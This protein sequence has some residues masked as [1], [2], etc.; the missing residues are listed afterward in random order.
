M[1]FIKKMYIMALHIYIKKKRD[2]AALGH[3]KDLC[4]NRFVRG[5]K[6]ETTAK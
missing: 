6:A 4:H 3:E 5:E 1:F 2:A